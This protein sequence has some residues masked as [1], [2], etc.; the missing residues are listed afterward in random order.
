MTTAT[1][2]V[3][4]LD[5]L[6]TP[7]GLDAGRF[8]ATIPP[9][10]TQ[11][12]ATFGGLLVGLMVRAADLHIADARRTLR[13]L[14]CELLAPTAPG[15]VTIAVETLRAGNA[16]STVR[17]LLRQGDEVHGHAVAVLGAA[18]S[19]DFDGHHL[20]PPPLPPWRDAYVATMPSPPVPE[21][22]Q[23]F[24]IRPT[25]ALPYSEGRGAAGWLRSKLPFTRRDA[26]FVAAHCDVWWPVVVTQM[27]TPRPV[28]TVAFTLQLCGSFDGLDPASPLFHRAEALVVDEGYLVEQRELWGEDGRLLALNQQTIAI[29]K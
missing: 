3:A 18:R 6:L 12:R 27:T 1:T 15:E 17:C 5:E 13:S 24:E 9:G 28:G 4:T 8:V 20:A 23:N 11:G 2:P 7:R 29:I 21:F 25:G 14:T 19:R 16:V 22:V 26:A 10:W